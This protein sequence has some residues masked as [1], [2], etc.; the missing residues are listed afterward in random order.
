MYFCTVNGGC[1]S[2]TSNSAKPSYSDAERFS[3]SISATFPP[4]PF[5]MS[6][7]EYVLPLPLVPHSA[8]LNFAL[9]RVA[10]VNMLMII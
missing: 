6:S 10:F 9:R 3:V 5:A 8:N 4:M 2:H 7:A 1:T